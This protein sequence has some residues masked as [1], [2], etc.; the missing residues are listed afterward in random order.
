MN[1]HR[2]RHMAGQHAIA[3]L[4]AE[5]MNQ[6]G[7]VLLNNPQRLRD[8]EIVHFTRRHHILNDLSFSIPADI[9]RNNLKPFCFFHFFL[10]RRLVPVYDHQF[11]VLDAEGDL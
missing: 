6:I 2:D 5:N 9:N 10:K 4:C 7:L 11:Q 3:P 1:D 8:D